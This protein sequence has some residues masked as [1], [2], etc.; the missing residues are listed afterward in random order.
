MNDTEYLIEAILAD[1]ALADLL[2]K[3][4]LSMRGRQSPPA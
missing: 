2:L 3:L 1:P 4:L